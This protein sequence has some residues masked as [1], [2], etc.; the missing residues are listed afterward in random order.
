MPRGRQK[1][2]NEG[3]RG[4]GPG[5]GRGR[6]TP[7][8]SLEYVKGW[9]TNR[10]R[11]TAAPDGQ[12]ASRKPLLRV[13]SRS[14][15]RILRLGPSSSDPQELVTIA[16]EEDLSRRHFTANSSAVVGLDLVGRTAHAPQAGRTRTVAGNLRLGV[17]PRRWRGAVTVAARG[18]AHTGV[19]FRCHGTART[20][21]HTLFSRQGV[22]PLY[23]VS[24]RTCATTFNLGP[25]SNDSEELAAV[26]WL[27]ESPRPHPPPAR[28]LRRRWLA[29]TLWDA[30]HTRYKPY[31]LGPRPVFCV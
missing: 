27:E 12:T 24:S 28:H 22:R 13:W 14:C 8:S 1:Q 29:S 6:T 26:G 21:P 2:G 9:A 30:Q 7:Q 15:G 10:D 31:R 16:W 4:R 5:R 23:L 20:N 17:D 25:S 19:P 11:A 18:S 3:G